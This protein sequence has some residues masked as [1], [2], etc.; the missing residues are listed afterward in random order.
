MIKTVIVIP[1]YNESAV[2]QQVVQDVINH[3]FSSII[4]VDDG[5]S[6]NTGRKAL[7]GG[8]LLVTH[9]F[10]RGKGA[11]TKTG[12]EAAKLLHA[13]IIVTMDADGQHQA[14]DIKNLIHPIITG[15][16]EV[17]LGTRAWDSQEVPRHKIIT[18]QVGNAFTWLL[19][20]Q[21]V[22]DSQSGLRAY[23]RHAASLIN[24]QANFYDYES[25]VIKEIHR[26]R[27]SYQEVPINVK[28]TTYSQSKP[29]KQSFTNGI[30]TAYR[31]LWR[32]IT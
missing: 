10:N 15:Q 23:S 7:A 1:A 14:K 17:A 6:D 26:H 16:A 25:E 32:M 2:I 28:Y 3:G 20:R 5:S 13:D 19:H 29:N 21:W 31:M 24:T 12:I 30:K 27:L 11:A 18:N 9:R 8:A 22:Q 4:V